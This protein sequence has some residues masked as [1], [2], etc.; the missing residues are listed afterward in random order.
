MTEEEKKEKQEK[1]KEWKE[2]ADDI[3]NINYEYTG[4][5][6]ENDV[7]EQ[8][9]TISYQLESNSHDLYDDYNSEF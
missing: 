5:H 3:E 8:F 1:I 2:K 9:Q 6:I 4:N 7:L